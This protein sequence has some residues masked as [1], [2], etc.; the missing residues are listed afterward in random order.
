M[1]YWLSIH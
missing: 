1:G